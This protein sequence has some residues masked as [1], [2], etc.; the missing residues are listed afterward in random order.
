[1]SGIDS[2]RNTSKAVH[3]NLVTDGMAEFPQGQAQGIYVGVVKQIVYSSRNGHLKVYIPDFGGNEDDKTSWKDVIYASP[4]MGRTKGQF[5]STA[6]AVREDN[7]FLK[8]RQSYGLYMVPP[9]LDNEVLCFFSQNRFEGYWFACVNSD[10]TRQMTPGIGS[11]KIDSV[12]PASIPDYLRPFLNTGWNYPVGE[13]VNNLSDSESSTDPALILKPIH[14]PLTLQ[15]FIQGLISDNARGPITSSSQRDPTSSVFGF[16]TPGRPIATQDP[17][18][19]DQLRS[20]IKSGNFN[21][22]DLEV[23]NRYQGHSLIMDD[24]DFN[25]DNNLVR[26]RTSAGHQILMNDSEGF[27]YI[28]NSAGTGWIE[29]TAGGDILVYGS[30]DLAVRMQGNIMMRSDRNISFEA[31]GDISMKAGASIKHEAQVIQARAETGLNLFGKVAQL[32][33]ASQT[34]VLSGGPMMLRASGAIMVNGSK[35]ALNGQGGGGE[36]APPQPLREYY[37]ADAR[38]NDIVWYAEPNAITSINTKVPTHE[39]YVRGNLA[40]EIEE[41]TALLESFTTDI[42][43]NDISPPV[44]L[45]NIGPDQSENVILTQSA[46]TDTFISQ[47]DAPNEIG[48]L[49]QTDVTALNAQLG[50]NESGGDYTYVAESGQIGKYA[51]T[52]DDLI[53]SGYLKEGTDNTIDAIQNPNNWRGSNGINDLESFLQAPTVQE[54]VQYDRTRNIYAQLESEG[55]ITSSTTNQEAAGLVSAAIKTSPQEVYS[56][57]TTG[58]LPADSGTELVQSYKRGIFS[59]TQTPTIIASKQSRI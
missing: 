12:D 37:A 54:R 49:T 25:N 48:I 31:M 17:A 24:G 30:N 52:A 19:N 46:P 55:L 35:I 22:A 44:N 8:G 51:L 16:S 4:Y 6:D 42:N 2:I 47:I 14:E 41:Q 32:R 38:I 20:Q 7:T 56:W 26:L 45:K 53:A 36:V 50:F 21:P 29:L 57:Y 59:Q 43:G 23:T 10:R 39:P 28:S 9:D 13:T 40:E 18:L 33:G 34:A 27:I 1:M 11:V 3:S 15:Y 58:N 5:P